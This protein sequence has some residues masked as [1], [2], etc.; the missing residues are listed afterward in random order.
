M[1]VGEEDEETGTR[2]AWTGTF[3]VREPFDP[4]LPEGLAWLE[5]TCSEVP[6]DST[7]GC[8]GRTMILC[9]LVLNQYT[10]GSF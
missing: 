7:P 2:F 1:I 5:S 3:I 6:Y 10:L 4:V 8:T 9:F